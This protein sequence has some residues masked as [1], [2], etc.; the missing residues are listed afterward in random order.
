LFLAL[1]SSVYNFVFYALIDYFTRPKIQFIVEFNRYLMMYALCWFYLE[2]GSH[3]LKYK[4]E[5][6]LFL[7]VQGVICT[8][9]YV[10]ISIFVFHG[11]AKIHKSKQADTFCTH[12]IYE[13]DRW[14]NCA[15]CIIFVILYFAIRSGLN[16]Q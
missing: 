12:T 4:D 13:L 8:L 15:V 16:K 14:L 1:Y 11:R 6:L 7:H 2:K 3:L 5:F 9:L 10:Y